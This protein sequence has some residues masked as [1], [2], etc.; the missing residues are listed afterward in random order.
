[1]AGRWAMTI[2]V[3]SRITSASGVADL[4]LLGRVDGGGGVV[5]HQHA[6][7]GEDG[8]GDGDALALAARQREAPLADTVA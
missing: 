3:R 8:P 7:V 4:V 1:M 6:G 5:E 2:V